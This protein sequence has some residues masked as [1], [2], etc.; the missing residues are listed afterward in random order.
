MYPLSQS[1]VDAGRTAVAEQGKVAAD[2]QK[3]QLKQSYALQREQLKG[4]I[5]YQIA[6]LEARSRA[7][8]RAG[9]AGSPETAQIEL[10]LKKARLAK[11]NLE[12]DA[13]RDTTDSTGGK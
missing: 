7:V 10:E 13:M 4:A 11:E 8:Q 1:M 2:M 6:A 5:N 3:E 12:L 9:G